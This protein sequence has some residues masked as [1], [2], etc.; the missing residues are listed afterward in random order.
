MSWRGPRHDGEFPSLGWGVVEFIEQNL[1]VPLG[2]DVGEPLRLTDEQV[3]FVVHLYRLDPTT[4]RLA[5][6]R[7]QL[8][9]AKGWGKSPLVAGLAIAE[10]CGPVRFGGWDEHGEPI[11]VRVPTPWVQIAATAEDQTDNTWVPLLAMLADSPLVTDLGLDVGQTRII[12]PGHGKIEYVTAKAGTREGQPITFAILDETH[13]WVDSN[14]GVALAATLRRNIAKNSGLS[15]ETTN[16]HT[17]GVRSVAER[18][19]EAHRKGQS[20]L[21]LDTLEGPDVED[22]TDRKKLL[23][24][25]RVAY[26]DATWVDLERIADDFVDADTDPADAV[27]FF[28]NRCISAGGQ[29][30][31]LHDWRACQVDLRLKDGDRVAL[32]FDGARFRDSTAIVATRIEDGFQELVGLWERPADVDDWEIDAAHVDAT[33]RDLHDRFTV[34][35]TFAD[36][37]YWQDQVD[38]WSGVWPGT[39]KFHTNRDSL[40]VWAVKR[41]L[42][43]VRSMELTHAG[44]EDLTRHIM[45]VQRFL[46]RVRDDNG[47]PMPRMTK[48]SQDS[49][50][51]IDAAMAS[52]LSWAAR[53]KVLADGVPDEPGPSPYED[54]GLIVL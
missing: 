25:L 9:R 26:G 33:M 7:S 17:P 2:S 40:M 35:A 3:R 4:G 42:D 22:P 48:V 45:N 23:A 11:G 28:L 29:L 5:V 32:G 34:L 8:R 43:A 51:H 36:P 1:V 37:P 6:R 19:E 10:L 12:W 21:L 30:V 39:Q 13:L 14:K 50:L 38:A 47:H 18:T 46:T 54:R 49:R 15:V 44:D 52:C 16:A 41:W 20:G 31:R 24:A 27:R 53:A